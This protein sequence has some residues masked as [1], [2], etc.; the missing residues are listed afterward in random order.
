M[1]VALMARRE[2]KLN[3][4]AQ[5]IGQDRCCVIVGSVDSDDDCARALDEAQSKLGPL[6]AVLANAGYGQESACHAMSIDEIRAM[7]ETNFYGSLRLVLPAIE[8][9]KERKSGHAIMVAS[10]LSKIGLPYYGAYCASKAA[11]DYFCRGMRL[12][13]K[14]QGVHVSSVHPVGTKT[15]FFDEAAKRSGGELK[16]AGSS[17]RFM[18]SPEKVAR[19]IVRCL[20][21]PKGE[22]WTSLPVRLALGAT[23]AMP[24]LTDWGLRKVMRKRDH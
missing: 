8:Q 13:L 6:H 23:V 17:E 16:R 3:A 12:E 18:Q 11:Q 5:M 14:G 19:A 10:C 24:G 15:E 2:D 7:F 4:V 20:H 1:K 9:F 22:V 21:K